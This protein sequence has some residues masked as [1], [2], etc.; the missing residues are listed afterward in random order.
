VERAIN[1]REVDTVFHLGAQTIVGT[2]VRSP[3]PTFEANVRGSLA[4]RG[5]G[6][7]QNSH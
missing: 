1:E 6:Q 7:R 5:I 3:L 4:K 2:A